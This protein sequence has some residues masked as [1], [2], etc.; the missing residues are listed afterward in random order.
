MIQCN[1]NR[2]LCIHIP[3]EIKHRYYNIY[4]RLA[5]PPYKIRRAN[6]VLAVF[7][8]IHIPHEMKRRYYPG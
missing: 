8:R 7:L 3:H 6:A 1:S 5:V 4:Y 2:D